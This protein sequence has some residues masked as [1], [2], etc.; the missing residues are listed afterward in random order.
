MRLQFRKLIIIIPFIYFRLVAKLGRIYALIF[1][2]NLLWTTC[3]MAVV[4]IG[5]QMEL[6]EYTIGLFIHS[7]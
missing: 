7:L 1:M 6:V 3:T 2:V 5:L 4:L